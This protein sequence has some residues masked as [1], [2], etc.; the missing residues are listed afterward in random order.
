MHGEGNEEVDGEED[1]TDED[2]DNP[3]HGGI[4]TPTKKVCSG[5]INVD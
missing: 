4:Q 3:S 5:T 2:S 1:E